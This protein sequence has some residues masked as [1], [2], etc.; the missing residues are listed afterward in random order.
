MDNNTENPKRDLDLTAEQLE[1]RRERNRRQYLAHLAKKEA[2][3]NS[4]NNQFGFTQEEFQELIK[5]KA[6][7]EKRSQFW[8]FMVGVLFMPITLAGALIG[9]VRGYN[10]FMRRKKLL[11]DFYPMRPI[12]RISMIMGGVIIWFFVFGVWLLA[13]LSGGRG[14]GEY[15]FLY[16]LAIN[17]AL[18]ALVYA[19]FRL[20]RTGANNA[21]IEAHKFGS[22][23]FAHDDELFTLKKTEGYYIGQGHLFDDLGHLL[24]VAGTRGGKGTNIIVPNLLDA[25]NI[26][27]SWVVIDPKG[28]NAAITARYQREKGQN[29]IILNP[30]GLL[31]DQVG[32]AQ[33][34]NPLDMVDISSIHFVDD[35]QIVA[36]MIVPVEG[37]AKD[38]FWAD[39]A[40]SVVVG[41]L[42]YILTEKPKEEQ[43]LGSLWELAR[44]SG[45]DWDKLIQDMG[46]SMHKHHKK[47]LHNAANEILKLSAASDETFGGI[48]ASVLQATDFLKSPAMQ[49]GLTTGFDPATLAD[50]KTT[51]YVI[52]PADKLKTHYRWLRLVITSLMRAVIRKPNERVTFLLD[53]FAALGYISEIEVALSTYAGYKVTVWPILQTLVQLENLYGNNWQTFI[54]SCTVR[55][56]FSVN[57]LFS[58]NYVSEAIGHTSNV[59]TTRSWFGVKDAESTQRLLITPDELRRESGKR[60]FMFI[61]DLPP[62]VVD[63]LPYYKVEQLNDRADKNP[64]MN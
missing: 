48:M 21:A 63:K 3:R 4:K 61:A 41:L 46:S 52:I 8:I 40:R 56:F 31:A 11:P 28:E 6:N 47:L 15:I 10:R 7:H 17:T 22:A 27:T 19:I 42:L 43:S 20:W 36:E 18:S 25:G 13:F 57:D 60:I 29:V 30:W 38:P 39:C 23:R 35:V 51:L 34:Y 12:V 53:E 1:Q 9:Y 62:T 59:L 26:Q 37:S 33:T 50:G 44:L 24:T 2:K 64:Y 14:Y 45:D 58:A 5:F 32:E 55:Q 49:T 54:S 16:Y